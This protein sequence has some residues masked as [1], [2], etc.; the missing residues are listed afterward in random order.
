[1]DL[2]Q[3]ENGAFSCPSRKEK[4]FA[5]WAQP[6]LTGNMVRTLNMFGYQDH[7]RVKKAIN[8]M[9]E[10]QLDDGGWNC[11]WPEKEV[12]H[13]SFTSTIEPLWAYSEIPRQKWTRKMKRSINQGAEFL[14]MHRVYK[15]DNHHRKPSLPFFTALHSP[16]YYF[17]DAL[18]G[19]RVLTKLGYSD[20][21]RVRDAVHLLLSKKGTDGKWVLDGDWD[22]ELLEEK[23]HGEGRSF[24]ERKRVVTLKELGKPSKRVTLNCYR[25]LV[26]TGDLNLSRN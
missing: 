13:S 20:D 5:D 1:M 23:S 11:D 2:H 24:K 16:M 18:H 26:K 22:R 25:A 14:L 6:C 7:P 19:L 17:Y 15:S 21:E 4:G 9:P 8:W 10:A 12:K 3:M